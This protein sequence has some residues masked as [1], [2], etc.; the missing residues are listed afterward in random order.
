MKV[1]AAL[2]YLF[3]LLGSLGMIAFSLRFSFSTNLDDLKYDSTTFFRLTGKR[4]W[5]VSWVLIGVGTFLQWLGA[6]SDLI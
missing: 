4:L 2:G 6:L 1:I 3:V 5:V